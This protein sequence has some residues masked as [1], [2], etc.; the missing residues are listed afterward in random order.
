[1]QYKTISVTRTIKQKSKNF[2]DP[3]LIGIEYEQIVNEQL[4]DGWKLVGIH[5]I[6]TKK[7]I[8]CMK[9][10]LTWGI[11]GIY[12]HYQTDVLIFFRED[13]TD[14]YTGPTY[15][16]E[17]KTMGDSLKKAGTAVMGAAQ[18]AK[19][20]ITSEETA[21]KIGGLKNMVKSKIPNQNGAKDE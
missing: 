1:M 4:A 11:C 6:N 9:I 13:G 10:M 16:S 20:F 17:Q 15:S 21:A 18:G 8:G 5:P 14:E 3:N 12:T 2:K 7:F 19:N